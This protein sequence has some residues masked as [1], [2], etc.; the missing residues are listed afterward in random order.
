MS[1]KYNKDEQRLVDYAKESVIK[2]N[3]ERKSNGG[4][5]TIY[6]FVLS[7]SGK[8]YDGACL[9]STISASVCAERTAI[10]SMFTK[11]TYSS[12]IICVVTF[13]PVPKKQGYS[14]T[15][16]GLCRH[17]I[18]EYGNPKTTVICGQYIQKNSGWEFVPEMEKYSIE[19]LYP[20]PYKAVKW[21]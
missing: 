1:N 15:P 17:V 2:Y 19:D 4:I 9:E 7:D 20:K 10:A 11:E 6:A 8:I 14:S 13:D 18:W 16:C 5:D 3:K 12:K 21:D